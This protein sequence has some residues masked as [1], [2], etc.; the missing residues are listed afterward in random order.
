MF[1]VL[2]LFGKAGA[3]WNEEAQEAVEGGVCLDE[4]ET[5]A[6]ALEVADAWRVIAPRQHGAGEVVITTESGVRVDRSNRV[7]HP[8]LVG[9]TCGQ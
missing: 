5:L 7:L 8:V 9:Y 3:A 4:V 6:E 1:N 2:F